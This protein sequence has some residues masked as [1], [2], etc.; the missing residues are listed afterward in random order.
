MPQ[1]RFGL[2]LR[3]Y[4]FNSFD[5][6]CIRSNFDILMQVSVFR[7]TAFLNLLVKGSIVSSRCRHFNFPIEINTRGGS[8]VQ[9]VKMKRSDKT[10]PS[11]MS[12]SGCMNY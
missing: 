6:D 7:H 2:D 10:S 11:D 9:R 1:Y 8:Q 12:N 4:F 3:V 5:V